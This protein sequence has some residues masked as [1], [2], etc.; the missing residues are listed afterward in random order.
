MKTSKYIYFIF[1]LII[2]SLCW[3]VYLNNAIACAFAQ[4]V[5]TVTGSVVNLDGSP[6]FSTQ[7]WSLSEGDYKACK[8]VGEEL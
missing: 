3:R 4:G 1:G 8:L 2:A 5:K 7:M 6:V